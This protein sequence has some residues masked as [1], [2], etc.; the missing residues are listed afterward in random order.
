MFTNRGSI[1]TK[2]YH[3]PFFYP[4]AYY[5]FFD[6]IPLLLLFTTLVPL[7]MSKV[8]NLIENKLREKWEHCSRVKEEIGRN[9]I[10]MRV[11]FYYHWEI[12]LYNRLRRGLK[13]S[14][15]QEMETRKSG[16]NW[17]EKAS[18]QKTNFTLMEKVFNIRTQSGY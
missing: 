18:F 12:K 16:M 5:T 13:K 11:G 1:C 4:F 6:I 9:R 10:H 2:F 17:W 3:R 14:E 7:Y 8:F 15:K